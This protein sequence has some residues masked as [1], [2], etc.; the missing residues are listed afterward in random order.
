[1]RSKAP[2]PMSDR[3]AMQFRRDG[4][5]R[6]LRTGAA[7]LSKAC[8]R[9]GRGQML[10]AASFA[11]REKKLRDALSITVLNSGDVD[12]HIARELSRL[13]GVIFERSTSA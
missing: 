10:S 6:S 4:V 7:E 3:V 5:K 9:R 1:M 12:G 8:A 2:P 11:S 13:A